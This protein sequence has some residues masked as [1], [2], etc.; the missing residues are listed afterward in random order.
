LDYLT[1]SVP[2][3]EFW[4]DELVRTAEFIVTAC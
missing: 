3:V 2:A 1:A 4:H